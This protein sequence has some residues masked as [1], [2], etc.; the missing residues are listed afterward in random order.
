MFFI[1]LGYAICV[2]ISAMVG[3]A[4]AQFLIVERAF[5]GKAMWPFVIILAGGFMLGLCYHFCP[6]ALSWALV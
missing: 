3:I 5:G 4:G 1:I 6:F 2:L